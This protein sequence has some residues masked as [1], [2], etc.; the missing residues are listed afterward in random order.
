MLVEYLY[1]GSVDKMRV[2]VINYGSF[3]L[4]SVKFDEYLFFK[5]FKDGIEW[6]ILV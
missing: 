4:I 3:F 6:M 2:V 5:G 1:I